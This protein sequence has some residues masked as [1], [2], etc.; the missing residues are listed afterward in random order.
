VPLMQSRIPTGGTRNADIRLP[1]ELRSGRQLTK[2]RTA[3]LL[4]VAK[5][6]A[7]LLRGEQPHADGTPEGYRQ[8]LAERGLL[9]QGR[10]VSSEALLAAVQ[11]AA[12]QLAGF[13][14]EPA[15]AWLPLMVRPGTQAPFV[16]A[17]H[18]ALQAALRRMCTAGTRLDHVPAG[19]TS[20]PRASEDHA[21]AGQL[22][23]LV[24]Q[25][26]REETTTRI[27]DALTV[28]GAWGAFRHD[29]RRYPLL[30]REVNRLRRSK[31][32]ARRVQE[33]A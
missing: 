31:A 19:C 15:R 12:P 23:E 16:T 30:N 32:S 26:L 2:A 28:I 27:A 24:R 13:G 7:A 29:R 21:F 18:V 10:S 25:H 1:H 5:L 20:R 6:S 22:R 3:Y 8:L 9:T 11:R 33:V 14:L 4:E 17:K